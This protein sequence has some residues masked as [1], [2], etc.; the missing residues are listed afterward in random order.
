MVQYEDASHLLVL[1]KLIH[2]LTDIFI[3]D[4]CAKYTLTD[5]RTNIFVKGRYLDLDTTMETLTNNQKW[6]QDAADRISA[7]V[8][9][10]VLCVGLKVMNAMDIILR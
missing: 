8:S 9:G 3:L 4:E 5:A 10:K 1:D 2:E 7:L 6:F